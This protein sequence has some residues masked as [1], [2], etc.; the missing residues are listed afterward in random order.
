MISRLQEDSTEE[1]GKVAKSAKNSR[2]GVVGG[3]IL[4]AS[5]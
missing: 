2:L 5:L 4:L 3:S 1:T